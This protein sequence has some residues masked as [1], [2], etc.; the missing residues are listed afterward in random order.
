LR[1]M[2]DLAANS[3][4]G[5]VSLASIAERQDISENYLEQVFSVL[6]KADIVKSVKG[7]GGGYTLSDSHSKITVG[8]IIRALEGDLSVTDT[9]IDFQ[10]PESSIEYCI[11]VNVWNKINESINDVVDSITIEE[12]VNEYK[13]MNGNVSLMFYI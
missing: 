3:A 11:S 1:A 5:H 7:A 9:V 8:S 4:G 13:K 12:L 2:I 10:K 6:R